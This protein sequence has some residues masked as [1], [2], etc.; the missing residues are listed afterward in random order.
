VG[1]QKT[2]LVHN[3]VELVNE[4]HA[5]LNF[6]AGGQIAANLGDLYDYSARRLLQASLENKPEVLDEV[7]TLLREIRGAWV[8]ISPQAPAAMRAAP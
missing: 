2:H 1:L 4:L 6:E 5:S 8:A 7:S 3:A